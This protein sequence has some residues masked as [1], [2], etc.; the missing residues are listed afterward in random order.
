MGEPGEDAEPWPFSTS[1]SLKTQ[2]VFLYYCL[3]AYLAYNVLLYLG[4]RE[5]NSWRAT[6]AGKNVEGHGDLQALQWLV[7]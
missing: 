6:Q 3:V 5:G 2:Y 1:F 4:W 7:Q